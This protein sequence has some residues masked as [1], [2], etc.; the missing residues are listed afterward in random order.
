M[1]QGV[2]H[3][4]EDIVHRLTNDVNGSQM[5]LGVEHT[6]E[7]KA[8][9]RERAVNGSQMPQG[10]AICASSQLSIAHLLMRARPH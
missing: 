2:E 6:D 3:E 5:P 1:P 9:I 7:E 8:A 4:Q 10:V